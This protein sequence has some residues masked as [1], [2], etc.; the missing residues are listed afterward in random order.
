MAQKTKLSATECPP[1]RYL[2]EMH[3]NAGGACEENMEDRIVF[4][5]AFH[6]TQIA[7][8]YEERYD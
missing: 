4:E 8:T 6:G 2:N 1:E 7:R 5:V 3:F